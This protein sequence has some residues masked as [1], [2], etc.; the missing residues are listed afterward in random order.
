MGLKK[1]HHNIWQCL[2]PHLLFGTS[3]HLGSSP[4][5]I[6]FVWNGFYIWSHPKEFLSPSWFAD[7]RWSKIVLEIHHSYVWMSP[8]Q[9]V[10][11]I[12][13]IFGTNEFTR[14]AYVVLVATTQP[15]I[16]NCPNPNFPKIIFFYHRQFWSVLIPSSNWEFV[17]MLNFVLTLFSIKSYFPYETCL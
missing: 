13:V 2:I 6:R 4:F 16:L 10:S 8:C 14:F 1:I 12:L 9:I 7:H 3:V 11:G 17:A 15:F 5:S